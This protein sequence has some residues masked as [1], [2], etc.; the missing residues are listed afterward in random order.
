MFKVN[1]DLGY[2]LHDNKDF[3]EFKDYER[4]FK[5]NLFR[6]YYLRSLFRGDFFGEFANND[7][8]G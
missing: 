2:K 1:K 5:D 7:P 8:H 4:F 6:F 3:T